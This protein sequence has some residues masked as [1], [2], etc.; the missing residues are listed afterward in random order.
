MALK[1]VEGS[2]LLRPSP[3]EMQNVRKWPCPQSTLGCVRNKQIL[4][5]NQK[6]KVEDKTEISPRTERKRIKQ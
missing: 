6:N 2:V 5:V 3:E 1:N 4:C